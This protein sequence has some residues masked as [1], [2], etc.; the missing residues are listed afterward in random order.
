MSGMLDAFAARSPLAS[1][2]GLGTVSPDGLR[3]LGV[4]ESHE[5]DRDQ[6]GALAAS[7]VAGLVGG[8]VTG[9]VIGGKPVAGALVA[10]GG[11]ALAFGLF[12][13][14]WLAVERRRCVEPGEAAEASDVAVVTSFTRPSN[15]MR[16][17]L[18][19]GGVI[20]ILLG[21]IARSART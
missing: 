9:W 5:L 11:T 3:E 12:P 16:A 10:T 14:T 19:V 13:P 18:G 20:L 21:F 2:E 1:L 6:Y 7:A 4:P 8:A 15:G 17:A